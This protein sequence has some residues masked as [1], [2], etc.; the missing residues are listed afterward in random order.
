MGCVS[1]TKKFVSW[2][3]ESCLEFRIRGGGL[4][5]KLLGCVRRSLQILQPTGFCW[6]SQ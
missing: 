1:H 6:C 4:A 2:N 3:A 5:N